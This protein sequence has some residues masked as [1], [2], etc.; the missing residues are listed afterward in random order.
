L[1]ESLSSNGEKFVICFVKSRPSVFFFESFCLRRTDPVC[2][3]KAQQINPGRSPDRNG[4]DDG[5][6]ATAAIGAT[7]IRPDGNNGNAGR[8]SNKVCIVGIRGQFGMLKP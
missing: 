1:K 2:D 4:D 6:G 3:P 5:T 7:D 8:R